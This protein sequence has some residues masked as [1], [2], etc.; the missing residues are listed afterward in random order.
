M[1][2]L[3]DQMQQHAGRT[4]TLSRGAK[5]TAPFTAVSAEVDHDIESLDGFATKFVSRDY[6][7]LAAD[8]VIAGVTI[9]PSAGDFITET[10]NGT[11]RMFELLPMGKTPAA[12]LVDDGL[13]WKVHTK[14]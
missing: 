2:W 5:S 4:V 13:R 10:I 14:R 12:E 7:F 11:E 1:A 9:E 3:N 8:V 6:T